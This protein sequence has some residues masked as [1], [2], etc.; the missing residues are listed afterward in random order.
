MPELYSEQA[1]IA[2]VL[3]RPE[4]IAE[5]KAEL[6]PSDFHGYNRVI[7]QTLVEMHDNDLPI[8]V[9]TLF[10]ELQRKNRLKKAGGK[11]YLFDI[12][13]SALTSQSLDYHVRAVKEQSVQQKLHSISI[14]MINRLRH[15][16]PVDDVLAELKDLISN[17]HIDPQTKVVSMLDG[18]RETFREIE[19][20]S[21]SNKGLTGIPSGLIDVDFYTS[22]W[23][24]GELIVIAGRPGMGKSAL[25]KDFAMNAGVPVLYF[26]LEMSVK[27]IQK[28]RL[29]AKSNIN[30]SKIRLGKLD[31]EEWE[32]LVAATNDLD[33]LP[34]YFVDV[35]YLTIDELL[36][37][38]TSMIA[39]H[40][41]GLVIID[42]LQLLRKKT[43][44]ETREQEIADIS[45]KL[46][47][48][49]KEH[50]IPV[51]CVAQLNRKCEER[52][53]TKK[54]PVL[55]DLRENGGIEQDA[56]VVAFV[57]R[58]NVYY[59]DADPNRAEFIIAKGRNIKIGTIDLFWDGEHQRFRNLKLKS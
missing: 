13:E 43:R 6:D 36:S 14:S 39:K 59:P 31:D 20:I 17:I 2:A 32:R 48:M 33:K 37:I 29:A 47:N 46:K 3:I 27:G 26:S 25:V 52:L 57:Y 49:A 7:Y 58:E 50:Q 28:R 35:G 45:R 55:S 22:G 4:S 5:V 38:T 9:G 42:Y 15:K 18:M 53:L 44:L 30:L 40:N 19:Q 8:D 51:I 1:L 34:I 12:A 24:P 54:R 11:Q 10:A 16:T 41:I 23:Q 56:D 21:K